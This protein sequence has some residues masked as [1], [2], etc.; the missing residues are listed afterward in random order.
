M[1]K[2]NKTERMTLRVTP[3]FRRQYE[4]IA[5]VLGIDLT[6]CM[7]MALTQWLKQQLLN[8]EIQKALMKTMTSPEGIDVML[9]HMDKEKLPDVQLALPIGED[10]PPTD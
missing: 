10:T 2:V 6:G 8:E 3:D 7:S 9:N 5:A 1:A 4:E